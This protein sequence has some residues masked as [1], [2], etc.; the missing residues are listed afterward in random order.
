MATTATLGQKRQRK[1][2]DC[3]AMSLETAAKKPH[4]EP[5]PIQQLFQ[6]FQKELDHR[7]DKYERIVKCSRDITI[8]SKRTIF[9]LHRCLDEKTR[10]KTLEEAAG[11]FAGIK[12]LFKKIA[13][14]LLHEDCYQF[15]R[16][17]SPGL[18]EFVEAF[19]F[20]HF[21]KHKTLVP[22]ENICK[23]LV[24]ENDGEKT[25]SEEVQKE[26]LNPPEGSAPP[27]AP[28]VPGQTIQVPIPP[29]E[30]ILG[31]ADLTGE[32]MR[33]AINSVGQGNLKTPTEICE[34][35]RNIHDEFI[36]FENQQRGLSKKLEVLKNSLK[37]VE[38]T[39]YNI[40]IRGSEVPENMLANLIASS[41][42][43]S[44]DGQ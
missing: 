5:S 39:C 28:G 3:S 43:S 14:E 37:K 26:V 18:Q 30:Y 13:K 41:N 19:S 31:I 2:D 42:D 32:L 8:Q 12:E 11:K 35:L 40:H 21:L 15:I 22:F 17:Y 33:L 36:M 1:S 6:T 24:F 23:E 29:A 34:M 38:N 25:A 27:Q 10:A 7:H 44:A 4:K 16:A 20:W 9:L